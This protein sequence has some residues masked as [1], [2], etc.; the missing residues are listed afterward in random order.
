LIIGGI[1]FVKTVKFRLSSRTCFFADKIFFLEDENDKLPFAES[2]LTAIQFS[3]KTHKRKQL[4]IEPTCVEA[5]VDAESEYM[6]VSRDNTYAI[7]FEEDTIV[8]FMQYTFAMQLYKRA[9]AKEGKKA[10]EWILDADYS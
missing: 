1:T 6:L 4:W 8:V 2:R 3:N 9:L 10:E 7:V 5:I